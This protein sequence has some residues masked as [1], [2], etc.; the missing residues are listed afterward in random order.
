MPVGT[1]RAVVL[2]PSDAPLLLDDF[3]GTAIDTRLWT[4]TDT[5]SKFSVSGGNLVCAGG[6][7]APAWDDPRTTGPALTVVAGLSGRF[8]LNLSNVGAAGNGV[9]VGYD[10]STP[11]ASLLSPGFWV[12]AGVLSACTAAATSVVLPVTLS[13]ATSYVLEIVPLN[14]GALWRVSTDGGATFPAVWYAST[15][16]TGTLYPGYDN[17][18]A[19]WTSSYHRSRYLPVPFPVVGPFTAANTPAVGAE[20]LTNGNM[21]TGNPP[22]AWVAGGGAT[23][24]GAADER[25]GGAGAQSLSITN[26][27]TNYGLAASTSTST[28][29]V[30]YR[31]TGWLKKV[32][33]D[34]NLRLNS[35]S[36][37]M[38]LTSAGTWTSVTGTGRAT[39]V[40]S[41]VAEN[42]N[43]TL[44]LAARA[45]DVSLKALT[46]ASLLD[47]KADASPNGVFDGVVTVAAGLQGGI[48]AVDSN[49]TPANG[50]FA[51]HDGTNAYL[52]KLVAG[53]WTSVISAAA[54]YSAGATVRVVR[55]GNNFALYYNA[56]IVGSTSAINGLPT[57]TQFG[58]FRTDT[59]VTVA[60]VQHYG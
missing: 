15:G 27:A 42:Q 20:L 52:D 55:N 29:G 60:S 28:A 6:K 26:G 47:L 10:A 12:K 23:L 4:V 14:P 11:V 39:D 18:D 32:T 3:S 7:A 13:T 48:A 56:A 41:V 31:L 46:L 34:I 53:T 45:D 21:E 24:A 17:K 9:Q 43:N 44:G 50:W 38:T 5:E 35:S 19:I 58:G 22:T 2:A 54:A 1:R 25:T 30:W 40:G 36:I 51:Y 8:E 33:A 57:L 59:S 49:T 37:S 16:Y